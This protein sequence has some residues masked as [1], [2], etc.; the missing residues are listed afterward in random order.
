MLTISNLTKSFGPQVLFK[1]IGFQVNPGEKVGLIGRNGSGKTTLF[2]LILGRE[3]PD[4]G[5]ITAPKNYAIGHVEQ[6]IRFTRDSVLQEACLGLRREE[7]EKVWEV[8]KILDGLGF[9]EQDMQRHPR[10][11]SGGFQVRINLARALAARPGMLLLDEPTNFLDIVSIRWLTRFFKSW[12]GEIMLI[13]HD[14]SFMDSI[15]THTLSIHRQTV[16]KIKGGTDKLLSQIRMQ[17]E[18]HE[19][20]RVHE[21]KKRRQEELFITR[22]RAK[23]RL[24]GMVQSRIKTLEKRKQLDKLEK[25]R[26]LKFS[27]TEAPFEAK[28][29]QSVQRVNFAYARDRTTL[30]HDFS[31]DIHKGDRIAVIGK[32]GKGKTTLMRLMAEKLKPVSGSVRKHNLT[33]SGFYEQENVSSLDPHCTVEEEISRANPAL[34]RTAV[35]DI[36]GAMMFEGDAALKKISVLSGG[37]KSRVC[38][39]RLLA[40]PSNLLLLDE[41]TNHLDQESCEAL[42]NAVDNYSGAVVLV[43]HNEGLLHHI[44][45]RLVVFDEGKHSIFESGY[46][47]FLQEKGWSSEEGLT[48]TDRGKDGTNTARR[49]EQR[50]IKAELLQEKSRALRGRR[51]RMEK[52]EEAITRMEKEIHEINQELMDVSSESDGQKI[53]DLSRRYADLQA[54]SE[55]KYEELD[56]VT[57]EFEELERKYQERIDGL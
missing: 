54:R 42:M 35:R 46:A 28:N 16:Q 11:F 56:R 55:H 33:Q 36:C 6:E 53:A 52:M 1:N 34:D 50:R 31:L 7:K 10:E 24:A 47:D 22:F 44:P 39:G 38:L 2:N 18:I 4:Q 13:T 15:T 17:E 25:I 40:T 49:R 23:A 41:P 14:R 48:R 5:E 51:N 29:L 3:Y 30:I 45:G 57:R 20:T 12:K 37:E 32:N 8:E 21:A 9:S 43:T 27:F 26:N 19:K